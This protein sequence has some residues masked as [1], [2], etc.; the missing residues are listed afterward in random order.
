MKIGI[1]QASKLQQNMSATHHLD[2]CIHCG[3]PEGDI[4]YHQDGECGSYQRIFIK[5]GTTFE[6]ATSLQRLK[7]IEHTIPYMEHELTYGWGSQEE[8]D[9]ARKE[10]AELRKKLGLGWYGYEPID[11]SEPESDPQH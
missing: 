5:T 7:E 1:Q 10:A 8:L 11:Q 2:R 3:K 9:E 6:N 4:R